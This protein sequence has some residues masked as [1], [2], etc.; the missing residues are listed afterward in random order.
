MNGVAAV[1]EQSA[2]LA[3]QGQNGLTHMAETMGRVMEAAGSINAK[4]AVLSTK[5]GNISQVVTTITKVADQ[6]NLL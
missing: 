1:A 2:L 4:L 6:T 5:A 3:G